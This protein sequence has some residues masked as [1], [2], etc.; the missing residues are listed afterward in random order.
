MI[1]C[2]EIAVKQRKIQYFRAFAYVFVLR[3]VRR[4]QTV[5][6]LEVYDGRKEEEPYEICGDAGKGR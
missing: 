5:F 1:K 6:A 3:H 2:Y 4:K